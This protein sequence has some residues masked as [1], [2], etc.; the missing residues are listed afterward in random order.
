MT[1]LMTSVQG[2]S[3]NYSQHTPLL[4]MET[5]QA[6]ARGKL[7]AEAVIPAEII[8]F[9]VGGVTCEEANQGERLQ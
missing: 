7:R 1:K 8:I 9:M 5:L 4:M 3:S 6:I 2:V